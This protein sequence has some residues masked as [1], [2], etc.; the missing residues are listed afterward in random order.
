MNI[1]KLLLRGLSYYRKSHLWVVLGTMLSTA[2]LVGALMIGDS[3]RSSLT[4][5]VENRLGFTEFALTSGD[6]LFRSSLA[7]ALSKSLGTS[8]A[9]LFMTNGIAVSEGGAS[10]VNSVQIVGVDGRFG[11]IGGNG[12]VYGRILQ[13]EVVVNKLLASRLGVDVG[14]VILIRIQKLDVM[15]RDAP[16]S[17]DTDTTLA[18]RYR[19]KAVAGDSEFGR[20]NLKADQVEPCSA[21]VSLAS[22]SEEMGYSGRANTLLVSR[23]PDGHLTLSQVDQALREVWTLADAGFEIKEIESPQVLELKT[24]RVFLDPSLVEAAMALDLSLQPVLTY[25]V[26]EIRLDGRATPYSFVSAPGAPGIP[27]EMKDEEIIINEWLAA[28]IGA[29]EGDS[30]RLSYFVIGSGRAL[31]ERSFEFKVRSVVP[32][33][34]VFADRDLLPNFPGLADQENCRDWDPGIPIDLDKIRDKDEDYWDRYRGT[35][36]AFITLNAAQSLWANRFGKLTALRFRGSSEDDIEKELTASLNPGVFGLQFREVKSDGLQASSQ[37][38]DFS[39]LFLGLSFFIVFAALLLTSLLFVFNTES[40]AQENGLYLALGFSKKTVRKLVLG[41]GA[42]LVAAGSLLGI[43]SGILY[44][45]LLLLALKTVWRGAV[46]TSALHLHLK[47]SSLVVGLAIGMAVAFL[48]IAIVSGKQIR[49]S[50]SGLQ[51]GLSKV[52]SVLRKKPR[53]SLFAGFSSLA[54]VFLILV[55]TGFGQGEKAV[56]FFFGAG[57]LLLVG[58]IALANAYLFGLGRRNNKKRLSLWRLGVRNIS[59]KRLRSITLIGLLASGLFIVFTVGAN[60]INALKD[61]DKRESGTGGFAFYGESTI[62]VLYDLNSRKGRQFY[63]LDRT[64]DHGVSFV[65]FRVKEGDDASCLNLNTVSNPRLIGVDPNELIQR[66]AFTFSD[67]TG[68][69]DPENPWSA[70]DQILPDGS[71][72]AVADLSVII[73]GLNKSVGDSL[74]YLDERGETFSLTLV[75]G[76][77]NSIFQGSIII[78]ER[79]FIE[80]FPSISGY[81]M[82]LVDATAENRAEV[83]EGMTWALEDQGLDLIPASTRLAEFNTVQNTYLSIFLILGSFG[84]LL[85]SL[86]LGIV[87]WRNVRERQ[88]ELALLRAVGFSRRSVKSVVLYEHLSL[89]ITGILLG[90]AAALLAT[91]PSLLTPG[92]QIPYPTILIILII[93]G[94]NGGIWTVSAASLATGQDLIPALRKE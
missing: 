72:P 48:T 60:R 13:D 59:R 73:W 94:L 84:L 9:P 76:L 8:V 7:D 39:Q 86:G 3:V 69:V 63:G 40:R 52:D 61:A 58:G 17:S 11:L 26:N 25:F 93:V 43:V 49:Q 33:E 53:M 90:I 14:D 89:L 62:P 5:I 77:A 19:V 54:G 38:V 64:P 75:G 42:V 36:K 85:G 2:V 65:Q 55:L 79:V 45:F 31:E 87:V 66:E 29:A 4:K 37:S 81:R 51:R 78:S 88:G 83:S 21:F 10:R 46:G 23:I 68:S 28:D 80:K 1:R 70:L 92:G 74:Q 15:P 71:V 56:V 91:L 82:I 35:P 67:T 18:R 22:M 41:E 27:P 47:F 24:G 32:L 20:F 34:G 50:I 44:N 57:G 12:G 6:R 16:L 30:V